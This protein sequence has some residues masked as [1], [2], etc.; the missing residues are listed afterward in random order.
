MTQAP[1]CCSGQ[2]PEGVCLR[3][4][5][6]R[7]CLK[8]W[9][10]LVKTLGLM[11]PGEHKQCALHCPAVERG[12]PAQPFPSSPSLSSS[13]REASQRFLC[14]PAFLTLE[15]KSEE[16]RRLNQERNPADQTPRQAAYGARGGP[17]GHS[18]ASQGLSPRGSGLPG[19]PQGP[20]WQVKIQIR[21]GETGKN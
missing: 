8:S 2:G 13:S 4:L 9:W 11:K 15:L 14:L 7:H 17:P 18:S 20:E 1:A 6:V 5:P 21:R 10:P 19:Q 3:N 16:K 12:A